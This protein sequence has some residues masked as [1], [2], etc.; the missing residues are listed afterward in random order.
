MDDLRQNWDAS[1]L[2]VK[3]QEDSVRLFCYRHLA[4][5]YWACVHLTRHI[6]IDS[7]DAFKVDA[8]IRRAYGLIQ[9]ALGSEARIVLRFSGLLPSVRV[10]VEAPDMDQCRKAMDDFIGAV[11]RSGH[12]VDFV[13]W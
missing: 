1:A 12:F 6:Q 5:T 4:R 9:E 13:D 8:E 11:K 7:I 10:M 3:A 2:S